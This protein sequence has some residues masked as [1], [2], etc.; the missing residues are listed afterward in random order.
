M[1]SS[2]MIALAQKIASETEKVE[3]Y[4]KNNDLLAPR[5]DA[6]A[7]GDFPIMPDDVSR[8]RREVIHAT[9]E[10]HDLMVGPRET[11]RWMAWDVTTLVPLDGSITF[12]ELQAKT[13]LDPINL[14][15]LLRHAMTNHVFQELKPGVIAHTAA[16]RL[17]AEDQDL[18]AWVIFNTESVYPASAQVV[19][20]LRT[21]PEATSLT[22]TGF[23]FAFDTVDLEPM[24]VTVGKDPKYAERMAQAMNSLTGGEGYELW[25]LLEGCDL[26][27]V[28]ARGGTLV[29]VGGSHGF[30]DVHLAEVYKN[31]K[32]V[33]QD[34]P[35]T[36][37]SAP[38]PICADVK[39]A[40]RIRFQEHDFF[41]EQPIHGADVYFFRW[42]MHNY[43][44]PYAVQILRNLIPALKPGARII[45]NDHCLREPGTENP[46]DERLIRSMDL[47]MMSLLNA[48]ERGEE[49]FKQLFDM[50][51]DGFVFKGVTRPKG[52]RMSIIEAVWQPDEVDQASATE[53]LS[54]LTLT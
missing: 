29:D 4:F 43:S 27:D 21:Y 18:Q 6:D 36:V 34:L 16:S 49:D 20:A 17:L 25:Y 22:R 54:G 53:S 14:A 35:S 15:R 51:G 38:K 45:I 12:S 1:A 23:N 5:F 24:F 48:Q 11:V 30:V 47:V 8:S 9:Q 40:K 19:K 31:I 33:V 52:C 44:T 10:L 46:W 3:A 42:I 13:S 32:F 26:T 28:D 37:E 41:K 50:A 7:P 39:I 2:K